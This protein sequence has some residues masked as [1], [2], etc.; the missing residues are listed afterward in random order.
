MLALP[1]AASAGGVLCEPPYNFGI[2]NGPDPVLCAIQATAKRFLD[3]R[4][5]AD[6][7]DWRPLGPDYRS[8]VPPCRVPMKAA[9]AT[10]EPRKSVLVSCRRTIASAHERNWEI[11]VSVYSDSEQRLY[12]IHLA[13][14][15][16]V[17][18]ESRTGKLHREAGYPRN[19]TLVPKCAVPFAVNWRDG[20]KNS[21]DVVCAKTVQTTWGK[22][23]W[24]V[25]V[26]IEPAPAQTS[27]D[28][29]AKIPAI[30]PCDDAW[31]TEGRK[32]VARSPAA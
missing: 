26:P 15:G 9:W 23:K 1:F 11:A 31:V 7:T 12:D 21:V 4:N 30:A 13:A 24:R 16:F 20:T 10:N 8:W 2:K 27:I 5:V 25:A 32:G 22:G 14:E 19:E 3:Q 17:R 18:S 6:K 29:W 28:C